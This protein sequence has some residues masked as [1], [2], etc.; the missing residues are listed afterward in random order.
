MFF[1]CQTN[2]TYQKKPKTKQ[3]TSVLYSCVSMWKHASVCACGSYA[4]SLH[5]EMEEPLEKIQKA[6]YT[7]LAKGNT[8]EWKG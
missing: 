7:A 2:V 3:K 8:N 5:R 6:G 4:C 1:K